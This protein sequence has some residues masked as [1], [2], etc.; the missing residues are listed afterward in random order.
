MSNTITPYVIHTAEGPL[1]IGVWLISLD[2]A[3]A[4]ARD[5]ESGSGK[6][7]N[8]IQRRNEIVLDGADLHDALDSVG[9]L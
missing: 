4:A 1:A 6:T 9:R 7:V 5:F 8:S 2:D 3:L